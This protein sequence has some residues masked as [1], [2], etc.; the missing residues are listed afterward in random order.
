[1]DS[2]RVKKY[3]P[4]KQ[5]DSPAT[6]VPVT[7]CDVCGHFKIGTEILK[8][9]DSISYKGKAVKPYNGKHYLIEDENDGEECMT[10][11]EVKNH[12]PGIPFT[13]GYAVALESIL[14]KNATIE[15]IE[16]DNL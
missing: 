14:S 15:A 3:L 4:K 12:L 6:R 11:T 2:P 7:I 9:F 8:K 5:K 13:G 10:H 16:L 1:M